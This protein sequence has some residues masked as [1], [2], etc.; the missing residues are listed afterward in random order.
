MYVWNC[1]C[2]C[3][4]SCHVDV[5]VDVDFDI[6]GLEASMAKMSGEGVSRPDSPISICT[7]QQGRH[8][9]SF[10]LQ[11]SRNRGRRQTDR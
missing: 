5:D 9:D 11:R 8:P 6:T 10:L 2:P 4:C 1:P 7:C 3:P